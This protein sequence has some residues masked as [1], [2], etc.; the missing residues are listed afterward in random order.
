MNNQYKISSS[1]G[2]YPPNLALFKPP[3]SDMLGNNIEK[4]VFSTKN[5]LEDSRIIF[6][7]TGNRNQLIDIRG[8]SMHIKGLI[9]TEAGQNLPEM[10]PGPWSPNAVPIPEG[11]A[12]A[13][14]TI[15]EKQESDRV[16]NQNNRKIADVVPVNNFFYSM[17]RDATL[18]IQGVKY[19]TNDIAY[20]GMFDTAVNNPYKNTSPKYTQMYFPPAYKIKYGESIVLG[21]PKLAADSYDLYEFTKKSNEIEMCGPLPFD[22]CEQER[23]LL[24]HLDIKIE[25][26]KHY[27]DF[28]FKHPHGGRY[29]FV[30]TDCKLIVPF[31]TLPP[32]AEIAQAEM[33][34]KNPA[35]YPYT[36]KKITVH[37]I[38][39]NSTFMDQVNTWSGDVPSKL[40]ILMLP[41]ENYNG[42]YKSDPFAFQHNK[43][44]RA[45]F[46]VDNKL[47]G[48]SINTKITD[49][50]K[51]SHIND[52]YCALVESY[53]L[54]ELS[55][56]KW[57][58]NFPA[59][60]FNINSS[61]NKDVLPLIT[62]GLTNVYMKFETP[63]ESDSVAIFFA[64]FPALME[65]DGL[66]IVS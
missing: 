49:D 64:E 12:P 21:H 8:I 3:L 45:E 18:S 19:F 25:L 62:K 38:P 6:E 59:F 20:R 23:L 16:N 54:M 51:T 28:I 65:I 4:V 1:I 40:T 2:G 43:V 9:K 66:R 63:I 56:N 57:L 34:T 31:V 32:D 50:D 33:L 5:T 15:L 30:L 7:I 13:D 55:R 37:S 26:I 42:S 41:S 24:S 36:N 60:H 35:L 11:T 22:I 27:S 47:I 14:K 10:P 58:N 44:S 29:K 61:Q 48:K 52:A 46:K 39:A 53:P 17:Y